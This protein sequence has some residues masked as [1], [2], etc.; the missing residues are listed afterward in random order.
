MRRYQLLTSSVAMVC[1]VLMARFNSP[2]KAQEIL[3]SALG[4]VEVYSVPQPA[5]AGGFVATKILLRTSDSNAKIVTFE[6]IK[7]S[8]DVHQVFDSVVM[9]PTPNADTVGDSALFN[10]AWGVFD[11]HLLITPDMVRGEAGNGYSGIF[12]TN[13]GAFGN[14]GLPPS[15]GGSDAMTGIGDLTMVNQT[16]A[17]FLDTPFQSNEV[18][19]AYLVTP[20][21]TAGGNVFLT[22]GV[23]GDG[24]VNSGD[25][26]G[27]SFGFN[28][29]EPVLVQFIPEPAT[30]L[31]VALAGIGLLAI[32]QRCLT[33]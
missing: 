31:L 10:G 28:G 9:D 18:E 20:A 7:I 16:D 33:S 4:G 21:G 22:L 26:G 29:N 3:L 2:V 14:G 24:I 1:V 19:Y 30:G 12:E 8:G 27:A 17:F 5:P 15:S 23:L 25:P 13:N 6:N 11:S 32:R